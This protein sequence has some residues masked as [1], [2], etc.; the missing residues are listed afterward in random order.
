MPDTGAPYEIPFLDGTELVRAYPQ[1][2]EDLA[3]QIVAGLDRGFR[4]AGTRYYTSSGTFAKADPLGTGDIGLRAVIVRVFGAGGGGR[5]V[6]FVASRNPIGAGG[7][8]A[9]GYAQ[10]FILAESLGTSET[11]TCGAGGSPNS[12]GGSSSFGTLVASNGG[13]AGG[14]MSD[15]AGSQVRRGGF[16]GSAT[17]GDFQVSG[18]PGGTGAISD[19]RVAG[20]AGGSSLFGSG[21]QSLD[22]NSTGTNGAPGGLG[23]GGSGAARLSGDAEVDGGSGGDGLIIVDCFV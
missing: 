8:G 14:L 18:S 5:G 6:A 20:G 23:G 21:G 15:L 13:F 19:L 10:S 4:F 9:G 16:G 17:A 3:D 11:V 22:D 7:G 12:N 2:S 1:F